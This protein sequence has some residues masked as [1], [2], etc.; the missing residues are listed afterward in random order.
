MIRLE[1]KN[2]NMIEA[3]ER[4]ALLSGKSNKYDIMR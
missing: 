2:C 1:T 3:A 4:S